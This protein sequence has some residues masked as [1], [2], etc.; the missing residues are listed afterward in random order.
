MAQRILLINPWIYDF[1][2]YDLWAKPWGLLKIS[3]ILK[4]AGKN[5]FFADTLD[6]HHPMLADRPCDRPDGTGKYVSVEIPKPAALKHVPRKYKRYGLG[7]EVF[8]DSL[9]GE[10]ID[11][12]LVSSGMT[13]WYPGA[14]EAIKVVKE[15][16]PNARVV[17]GGT[18]ATLCYDHAVMKS[19]AGAVVSNGRIGELSAILDADAEISFRTILEADIDYDWYADP[20]YAVVRL[21]LG[22]PFDCAYCAQKKL[23]PE[24]FLKDAEKAVG[25]FEFLYKRGI[26]KFAFYD[27]ALLFD[28]GYFKTYLRSLAAK[29]FHASFY[30]PNGLHARFLDDETA[31]LMRSSG[32]ENPV[33]SL[34]FAGDSTARKWHA[35]VTRGE[36]EK[37]A[38]LLKKAGYAPGEFTVYLM[39]GVPGTDLSEVSEGIDLVHS[40]GGKVSLSEFSPVPGTRLSKEA[41]ISSE[42]PLLH[43]NSIYPFICNGLDDIMKVKHKASHLNSLLACQ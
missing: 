4:K 29:G 26:R 17:L 31:S 8:K 37:A 30:T 14:F 19:G 2:A 16:Y 34:E 7:V 33:L 41:G 13:Y 40:L 18:Y 43:N 23:N 32:F 25:E 5:V 24:F 6:R 35:K 1:A 11:A 36:L 10:D 9:P 27:D 22:C 12:V 21:S 39:L 42:E 15:K 38:G 20:S 28:G 3:S